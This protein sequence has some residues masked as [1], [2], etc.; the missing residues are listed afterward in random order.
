MDRASHS[1]G[2]TIVAGGLAGASES[3]I[4]VS[5]FFVRNENHSHKTTTIA[6][7]TADKLPSIRLSS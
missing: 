5:L 3:F 7:H 2:V 1:A 4:T 6:K